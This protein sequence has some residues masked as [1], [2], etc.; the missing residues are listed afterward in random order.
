V[1]RELPVWLTAAADRATFEAAG[2]MGAF[3][4]TH[5]LGQGVAE[6]AEKIAA[7][8]AAWGRAGHGGT[9]HVT[10]MLHSFVGPDSAA[11]RETVRGP[12]TAYLR[13]S[14]DLLRQH[15][16]SFPAFRRRPGGAA[17]A[18]DLS[19]LAEEELAALTDHAFERYYAEAGL[20]GTPEQA[21]RMVERVRAAGVDEIACLID[22]GV[23]P[24]TVLDHLPWLDRLRAEANA[25]RD[26]SLAALIR[27]HGVTHLQ[28]TPSLARMMVDSGVAAASFGGLRQMLVGGEALP[29][30]LAA[31]LK[32][33]LG[34]DLLHMYG[35]TET[36]VWSSALRVEETGSTIPLGPPLVNQE[37]FLLDSRGE[38][39][40]DGLP[41]EI[42]IA[43]HGLARGY[44]GRPD[45]TAERFV[46]HPWRAGE[47][48]YRTGDLGR[49]RPDGTIAFLGRIDQ[50]VKLRG[51]RIEPGEIEAA[52]LAQPGIAEALV[53]LRE[54]A[55]GDPCLCAYIVPRAGATPDLAKLRDRLRQRLPEA[56][57]PAHLISLA[58]LPR[59]PNGKIDRGALP[60][61]APAP[62]QASLAPAD[63][64][65]ARI[66]AVWRDLLK[67]ERIGVEDNFF[68]SGGHSLLAVQLH[69]RLRAT[70]AADLSII[71]IF[72][73]P[74]VR[75]LARHLAASAD[76][77][78]AQQVQD[79][80]LGRRAALGQRRRAAAPVAVGEG[81]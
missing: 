77:A 29:P 13:S 78:A 74:T 9:P 28:C 6:L 5:L 45:L 80:A 19:T 22:F 10:L 27:R 1:Q 58:A 8:R 65:E 63:G 7:Y 21:R 61:P 49:L 17:E 72:R 39:V 67:L 79:R 57:V 20:F 75:A 59:T 12:L 52:L 76:G 62:V 30:G 18:I 46:A 69:R 40:P 71:D 81:G 33:T 66:A 31:E 42:V 14:A 41:G 16:W 11:V 32:R 60:P 51:H 50:Q 54:G 3:L 15:A 25:D 4:L 26:A 70:V 64:L 23:E 55:P 36:T 68:D 53:T 35:P 48:A 43:G 2:R 37:L 34:G 56:T 44:L 24:Q 47:R 38:P 73:F